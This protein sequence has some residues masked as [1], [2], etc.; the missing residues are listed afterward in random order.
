VSGSLAIALSPDGRTL[1]I[2]QRTRTDFR[3]GLVRAD[4][5]DYREIYSFKAVY[6][7]DKLAWTKDGRGIV[8]ATATGSPNGDWQ[9][10]RIGVDGG[11][12][13]FTGLTVKALNTFDLS[14]D[15]SRIAFSTLSGGTSTDELSVVDN[16]PVLLKQSQ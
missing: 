16:L 2:S 11:K 13:E 6:V 7:N 12:P 15:G 10:M 5:S 14:P 1:A 3:L 8:F 4:G 9:I